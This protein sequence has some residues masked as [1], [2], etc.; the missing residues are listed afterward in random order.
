MIGILIASHGRLGEEMVRTAEFIYGEIPRL[1]AANLGANEPPAAHRE[2]IKLMIEQLD[3]G[4]GVLIL[5]DIFG[6]TPFNI[7]ITFLNSKKVEVVAGF[8]LAMVLKLATARNEIRDISELARFIVEY[9]RK[10][11]FYAENPLHPKEQ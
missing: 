10:K 4:D 11:I 5:T 7:A 6:G 2:K 3:E 1:K 8:T 9:G